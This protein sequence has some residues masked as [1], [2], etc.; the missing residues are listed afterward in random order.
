MMITTAIP[1]NARP[2]KKSVIVLLKIYCKPIASPKDLALR[3]VLF[4]A[5]F[6][7]LNIL[8]AKLAKINEKTALFS[9]FFFNF[10]NC[11]E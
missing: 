6:L 8:S 5:I 9:G 1:I 2:R 7:C 10:A 4:L 3:S 11:K